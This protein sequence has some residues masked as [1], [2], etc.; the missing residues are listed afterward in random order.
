SYATGRGSTQPYVPHTT[1]ENHAINRR[2]AIVI[3]P[4]I[5]HYKKANPL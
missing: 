5:A 1:N 3:I 2:V 4:Y